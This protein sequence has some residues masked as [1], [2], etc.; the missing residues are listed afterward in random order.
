MATVHLGKLTGAGGFSRPVAIKR[1]HPHLASDPELTKMMLD[2]ARLA[3]RIQHPHVVSVTDVVSAEGQL[4]L[5]MEYVHGEALHRVLQS[6]AKRGA[7]VPVA[8]ASCIL[9]DVLDG[10]HAAHEARDERGEPLGLVHRDVTPHNLMIRTDGSALVVDF[11]VAKASGRLHTTEEGKIK[12]KLPYMA[13]EQLRGAK[14]TRQ[15]DIYAAGAVLFEVLVGRRLI[16][17]SNEGELLEQ[18]L[19]GTIPCPSIERSDLPAALDDVILRALSRSPEDR[20]T[21]AVEMA[22]A[23]EAA[24]RP[25]RRSEVAEWLKDLAAESLERQAA[26]L[27]SV[28]TGTTLDT[29]VS[30]AESPPSSATAVTRAADPPARV[31]ATSDVPARTRSILPWAAALLVAVATGIGWWRL[32]ADETAAE[33][34]R[35]ESTSKSAET[36][37]FPAQAPSP[38]A[39][40]PSPSAEAAP[41]A[42][43][44]PALASTPPAPAFA[45]RVPT[46][47][48]LPNTAAASPKTSSPEPSNCAP[49]RAGEKGSVRKVI[50]ADGT[51]SYVL[52]CR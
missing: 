38:S 11:G 37:P 4:L 10:L 48:P 12:G 13:P 23:L 45:A 24:A 34:P 35:Q 25:A 14:P 22:R 44:P 49:R 29:R 51:P 47:R 18:V 7:V 36:A 46:S 6:A 52:L 43:S 16:Q 5:V 8:I 28:E 26:I 1:L 17:G 40:S 9:I 27:T 39:S 3:G 15:I 31:L 20:Y 19:L 32:R 33:R 30:S 41:T 21:S 42:S 50:R 2:E